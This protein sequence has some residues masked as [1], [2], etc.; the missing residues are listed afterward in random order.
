MLI[1]CPYVEVNRRQL[2]LLWVGTFLLLS[3]FLFSFRAAAYSEIPFTTSGYSR[4]IQDEPIADVLKNFAA[5]QGLR[6]VVSDK[7]QGLVS[8]DFRN[9]P[10]ATFFDQLSKIYGLI[11]FYD[12][13]TL[14][15]SD[16][17]EAISKM[18][19][20]G[21]VNIERIE[22]TL[23]NFG[24]AY[25]AAALRSAGTEG[26]IYVTGEPRLVNLVQDIAK[27][28]TAIA[29][30]TAQVAKLQPDIEVFPLRYAW[31]YD[32]QFQSR[33]SQITVPGVATTLHNL[34]I[35]S[36]Q[37][38]G[39]GGTPAGSPQVTQN[40]A[41]MQGLLGKGLASVG[42]N[43]TSGA[44]SAPAA[45]SNP[46]TQAYGVQASGPENN[47][48]GMPAPHPNADHNAPE[49]E[50]QAGPPI[51]RMVQ[52]DPRRNAVIIKDLKSRIPLYRKVIHML[53]VPVPV[54]EIKS[55][56]IDIN[57]NYVQNLGTDFFLSQRAGKSYFQ[58]G[59]VN[60]NNILSTAPKP[61]GGTLPL[62][63]PNGIS[64]TAPSGMTIG[65]I[66][67]TSAT[68]FLARVQALEV[69][70]Y[71]KIQARPSVLTMDNQQADIRDDETIYIPVGGYSAVDLFNVDAGIELKVTP[72]VIPEADSPMIKLLVDINDGAIDMSQTVTTSNIPT[73]HNSTISTQAVLHEGQ[74]LLIGGLIVDSNDNNTS[75]IPLLNR[76]PFVGYLFKTV[77]KSHVRNERVFLISPR[78][79]SLGSAAPLND[80][81]VT[82]KPQLP[83]EEVISRPSLLRA[84]PVIAR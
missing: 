58:F 8:G 50:A 38:S 46:A 23:S 67:S 68:E 42:T 72:H 6:I 33:S 27:N 55:A 78:I 5:S 64:N 1:C 57:T 24:V 65:G 18:M 19:Q 66:L 60:P 28:L 74:S 53:D 69:R 73:V 4:Y 83:A 20:V 21:D 84:T 11:W 75:G 7:V 82:M 37:Q 56:I 79:V 17:S 49:Q 54:I 59:T 30:Q 31:A 10:P 71:A 14:Y 9:V 15:V 29:I 40:R 80:K 41:A 25:S 62:I 63:A 70:N 48:N 32:T 22:N 61:N 3:A 77:T 47:G 39:G 16:G 26:L 52:A 43:S 76:L 51:E 81:E 45:Y 13:Y 35:G 44:S 34:I 12:G 36:Q 2:T